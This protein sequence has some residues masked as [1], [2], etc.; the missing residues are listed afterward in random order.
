MRMTQIDR[1][2]GQTADS[3][4]IASSNISLSPRKMEGIMGSGTQF[5]KGQIHLLLSQETVAL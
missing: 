4:S 1:T 2:V 3:T 5:C